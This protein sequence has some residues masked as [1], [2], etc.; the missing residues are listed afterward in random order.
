ML[1]SLLV[2]VTSHDY[3]SIISLHLEI[4][5][6]LFSEIKESTYMWS[7]FGFVIAILVGPSVRDSPHMK[8]GAQ[9]SFQFLHH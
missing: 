3:N 6:Y 2:L 1:R 9:E 4:K 5:G 8:Q 7:G